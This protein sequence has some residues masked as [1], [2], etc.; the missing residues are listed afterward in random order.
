M[1]II[2]ILNSLIFIEA[3]ESPLC[4]I[5]RVKKIHYRGYGLYEDMMLAADCYN[6]GADGCPKKLKIPPSN[7]PIYQKCKHSD[8][9]QS[10]GVEYKNHRCDQFD[11]L[12]D[13]L[14]VFRS[15]G[16]KC[17]DIH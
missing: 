14:D 3:F 17:D 4:K 8:D 9:S 13:W 15:K 12:S 16:W 2:L 10:A 6:Y 7:D 11:Y 5:N 1:N